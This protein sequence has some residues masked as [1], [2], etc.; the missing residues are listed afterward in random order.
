MSRAARPLPR[1]IET[2][3]T[4]G[5][6]GIHKPFSNDSGGWKT[7]TNMEKLKEKI[8]QYLKKDKDDTIF[9]H[10]ERIIAALRNP[11]LHD[12]LLPAWFHKNPMGA[13]SELSAEQLLQVIPRPV[14]EKLEFAWRVELCN[15][16]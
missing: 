1:V 4:R 16:A 2:R 5:L 9:T 7:E 10:E 8:H 13:L 15:R 14:L 11:V 3:R 6:Y 12:E